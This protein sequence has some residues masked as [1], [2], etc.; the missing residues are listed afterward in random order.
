MTEPAAPIVAVVFGG[1]IALGAFHAGA[2]EVLS[3]RG[4]R[5]KWLAGS[6]IGAVTAV[7]IAGNAEGARVEALKSFWRD[8]STPDIFGG[9]AER[10]RAAAEAR[11]FGRPRLFSPTFFLPTFFSPTFPA[12]G[13]IFPFSGPALYSLAPLRATLARLADFDRV[14]NGDIRVSVRTT[15]IATGEPV[16]VDTRHTAVHVEHVAASCSIPVYFEP[17]TIDGRM[18][19]DGA[20]SSNLPIGDLLLP[21]PDRPVLCFALDLFPRRGEVPRSLD[22]TVGRLMDLCFSAQSHRELEIVRRDR[23]PRDGGTPLVVAHVVY[24]GSGELAGQKVFDFSA[25]AIS[26]RQRAGREAMERT[27]A[28]LPPM[29]ESGYVEVRAG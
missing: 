23:H 24:D 5:P 14:N 11:M 18:L 19:C 9:Q 28:A 13:P 20:M 1:G 29:P 15:D 12:A 17:I 10:R 6:S 16:A 27:L 25:D 3:E 4:F 7:L 26:A 2:Y 21:P 22:E 8:A